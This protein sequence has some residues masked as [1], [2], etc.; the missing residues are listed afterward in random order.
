ALPVLDG[1]VVAS[2]RSLQTYKRPYYQCTVHVV[3]AASG[4]SSVR[5]NAKITAWNS[6][7]AH[8]GY[9]VLQSNGRIESDLL[10]R[11]Q[12]SLAESSGAKP[13]ASTAN[14]N[15]PHASGKSPQSADIS[16]PMPQLPHAGSGT[17]PGA[18][19]GAEQGNK[20]LE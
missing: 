8:S 13:V 10:D 19:T 6:D 16:A 17:A 2:G 20:G 4:G 18:S 12:E 11:L 1:F 7:P 5:I 14:A 3:P 9:E 15:S